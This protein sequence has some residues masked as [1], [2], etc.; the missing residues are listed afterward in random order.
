MKQGVK[1][2]LFFFLNEIQLG[3]GYTK[4]N[5][6]N[7]VGRETQKG[8]FERCM[9]KESSSLLALHPILKPP[10]FFGHI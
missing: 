5:Y 4:K 10:L 6:K 3:I 8:R 2:M 9:Q 1:K 7:G